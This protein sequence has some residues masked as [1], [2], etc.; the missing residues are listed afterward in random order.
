MPRV[1]ITEDDIGF[2]YDDENGLTIRV[3]NEL[4][5]ETLKQ[6]ILYDYETVDRWNNKKKYES[7]IFNLCNPNQSE[8][9]LF[10]A[11]VDEL[12]EEKR[13]LMESNKILEAHIRLHEDDAQKLESIKKITPKIIAYLSIGQPHLVDNS[14]SF[15]LALKLKN[16][17]ESN[18]A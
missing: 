13:I 11:Q 8:Y 14:E 1:K 18:D 16:L 3:T 15:E 2:D 4:E 5:F 17:V 10:E 12:L 6:Q 9:C 7:E